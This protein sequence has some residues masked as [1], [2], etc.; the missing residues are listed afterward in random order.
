MPIHFRHFKN[1]MQSIAVLM[2][3]VQGADVVHEPCDGIMLYSFATQQAQDVF[4]EVGMSKKRPIFIAGGPHPS[5]RPEETLRFFDYVVI[6]EGEETLPELIRTIQN[7]G[8]VSSVRG[9]AFKDKNGI[10]L[11]D[12]RDPVMLDSYPPFGIDGIRSTIEITRGCPF[13]CAYCQ[14]PQLF[15]QMMRHRSI[16]EIVRYS[17]YLKDVRFTS[18]N[19]FAYGSDG[20]S[21][22]I[23]KIEA[24]LKNLPRKNIFFGTFPSEVRPEFI[25]DRILELVSDHCANTALC[26]GGQSGSQ[27]ILDLIK[28][29]HTVDDIIAG[30]E[31]CLQHGFT[32]VVDFIFGLPGETEDDQLETLRL[33]KWLT[34]KG[35]TVHS[36]YFMQLPGTGFENSTPAPLSAQVERT[37]GKLA[38]AGKT[39]GVWYRAYP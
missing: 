1:C 2:P 29:G 18:P 32:P 7:K 27:R 35:G 13:S 24:L 39:T 33:I 14:T 15:G 25:N 23:E 17:K 38:L 30:V 16:D 31:K 12:R 28:R 9:I 10:V 20:T 36:H 6:G 34:G 37:M 19:A 4:H 11:T 3:L 26:M 5:A 22:R 8:D 21:P